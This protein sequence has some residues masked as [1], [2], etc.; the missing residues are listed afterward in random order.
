LISGPTLRQST[1]KRLPSIHEKVSEKI[2]KPADIIKSRRR[3]FQKRNFFGLTQVSSIDMSILDDIPDIDIDKGFGGDDQTV[4]GKE[5]SFETEEEDM[6]KTPAAKERDVNVDFRDNQSGFST[7]D[8]SITKPLAKPLGL[9][10]FDST[11]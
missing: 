6:D 11:A 4:N 3:M 1:I 2:I 9:K 8:F 10:A 7:S 5:E